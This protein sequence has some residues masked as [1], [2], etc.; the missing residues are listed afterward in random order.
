MY[1]LYLQ[2]VLKIFFAVI[3]ANEPLYSLFNRILMCDVY[4]NK[5]RNVTIKIEKENNI[6]K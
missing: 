3:Q 2:Y 1:A 4:N 6:F 5:S